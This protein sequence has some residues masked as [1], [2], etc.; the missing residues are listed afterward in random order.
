MKTKTILILLS[1]LLPTS[2]ATLRA[3]STSLTQ[4]VNPLLGTAT[5][6][7]PEDLGYTHTEEKRAWGA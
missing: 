7:Q 2:G 3:Q 4:Y 6:W 1:I 5:L